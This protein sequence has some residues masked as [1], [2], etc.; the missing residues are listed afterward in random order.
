MKLSIVIPFYNEEDNIRAVFSEIKA[1]LSRSHCEY[2]ILAFDDGSQ[3][4]TSAIL[5]ELAQDIKE[6]RIITHSRNLGQGVCLWEGL[7]QAKQ[8]VIVTLDG[9]GQND[10]SDI[11]K[12]LPL[13]KD[14]DAVLGQR[15]NRKDSFLKRLTSKIGYLCR[16]IVLDDRTKDTACGLK[17]MKKEVIKYFL[18]LRNFYLFIPFM[19]QT[20][21]KR[22][23]TIEVNHRRRLKGRSKYRFWKFFFLAYLF[24]LIFMWGYRQRN[25]FRSLQQKT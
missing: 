21:G 2:E 16:R 22:F 8:E 18:P 9:D 4:K 15:L 1:V 17:V 7:M 13:L 23:V 3:D 12:M 6:L 24:D 20:A 14:Y 5:Q 25:V 11:L 19:L 10:F